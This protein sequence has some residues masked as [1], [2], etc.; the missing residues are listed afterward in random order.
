MLN[1]K[2]ANEPC[3][4]T[5]LAKKVSNY[6]E[7]DTHIKEILR[8]N[9]ICEQDSYCPY[10]E[11]IIENN[12]NSCHIE[13]IKPQ[14]AYPN[15]SKEYTNMILSCNNKNTCGIRKGNQ[16]HE[17][18][19]NPTIE[20]PTFYLKYDLA[21]GE[22]YSVDDN[23][24]GEYT[25]KVLN[26]N[27]KKLKQMRRNKIFTYINLDSSMQLKLINWELENLYGSNLIFRKCIWN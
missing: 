12:V 5:D 15:Q 18:F 7:F 10:C 25:I 11:R 14:S 13:H 24:K 1:N 6:Q 22:V 8:D 23:P 20:N 21:S 19:I 17:D 26:L 9:F 4:Y 16:Y 2:K 3:E 27:D